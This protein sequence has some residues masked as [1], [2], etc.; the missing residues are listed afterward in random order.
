M[1]EAFLAGLAGLSFILLAVMIVFY[2]LKSLGVMA[3][4]ANKGIENAWLAWIPIA[5]LYI[6]GSIVEEMDLFGNRLTNLGMWL[7]VIMVGGIILEMIP[8]IGMLV[9]L[10]ILVF[11]LLFSYQLFSMYSP[12]QAVLFT[13]L[14]ILGLW[15]IFVFIIRNNQPVGQTPSEGNFPA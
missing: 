11:F 12:S 6:L 13:V 9:G 1:S 14:S 3:M 15:P 7:P 4:A 10:A 8:I 5:D 2:V